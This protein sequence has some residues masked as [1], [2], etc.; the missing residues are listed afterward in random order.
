M[1]LKEH[2]RFIIDT[3]LF[4][5]QIMVVTLIG[6]WNLQTAQQEIAQMKEHCQSSLDHAPWG[7]VA[8][9]REWELATPP[10]VAYFDANIS[11]F[12]EN[13]MR[14]MAVIP[15]MHMQKMVMNH[16]AHLVENTPFTMEYFED[17]ESSLSWVRKQLALNTN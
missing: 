16:L 8:D 15:S 9:M 5:E 14:C 12:V 13:N 2:G 3:Q 4:D 17:I 6:G 10:V 11:W 1:G 7:A